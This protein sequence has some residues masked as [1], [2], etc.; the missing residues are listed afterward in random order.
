MSSPATGLLRVTR[1]GVL[2]TVAVGLALMS[3]TLSGGHTPQPFVLACVTALVVV[4]VVWLSRRQAGLA[5]SVV[6]LGGGQW[7]FHEL[8]QTFAAPHATHLAAGQPGSFS[9]PVM[10]AA[11]SAATLVTALILTHGDSVLWKLWAWLTR[12]LPVA[13][14]PAEPVKVLLLRAW[15]SRAVPV[16]TPGTGVGTRRGPPLLATV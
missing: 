7:C 16:P 15:F 14:P 6:V 13:M 9:L 12:R 8:A 4:A 1:V 3:H 2:S 5:A 10:V 11:H